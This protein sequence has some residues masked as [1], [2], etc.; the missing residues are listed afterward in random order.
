VQAREF[1][2][3]DSA[4]IFLL[5]PG[6]FF[7]IFLF[8]EIG[9]RLA[10]RYA[11]EHS[12]QP[13]AVFGTTQTAIFALL[14]LLVAFTFSG[15]AS[16]F[17]ARRTL[18][19]EEANAIGTAYLRLDLLPAAKQASLRDTFRRYTEARIAVYQALPDV[20][21]SDAY[22]ARATALQSEIWTDTTAALKQDSTSS[23]LVVNALNTMIDI[24]TTRS[25]MLRTHIPP[26]ALATLVVLILV[27]SLLIGTGL[28]RERTFGVVLHTFCFAFVVT[29][30]MY[31]IF[32]LD[33][34]RV[35]LIRLDYADRAL[36]DVLASMK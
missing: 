30:T 36:L 12:Q 29:V 25:I 27:C 10:T 26:I 21:A 7:S 13:I 17:E 2:M 24:T 5:L 19:V 11:A 8:I 6:F 18:T 14:G 33:H 4:V 1:V 9:H 16:R 34:P 22:A 3:S 31:V 35:G 28:P 15:A 23:V 32:D 20:A